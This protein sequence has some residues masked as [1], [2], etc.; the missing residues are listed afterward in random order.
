MT[1]P[2]NDADLGAIREE[3]DRLVASENSNEV[4]VEKVLQS[5]VVYASRMKLMKS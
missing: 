2:Q 4:N 5:V 1:L 3:L